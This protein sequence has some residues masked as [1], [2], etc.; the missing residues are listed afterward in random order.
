MERTN[1][2]RTNVERT[3]MEETLWLLLFQGRTS[4]VK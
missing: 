1:V 4:D 2:E 3:D